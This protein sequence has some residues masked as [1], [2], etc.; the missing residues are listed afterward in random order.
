MKR[1][2]GMMTRTA[3]LLAL[4]VAAPASADEVDDR[5]R[6]IED[7]LYRIKDKLDGIVSDGSCEVIEIKPNSPSGRSAGDEQIA[8]RRSVLE[9]MFRNN[10]LK[11]LLQRCVKDGSL[12]IRY[13][14]K[15][16]EYCPVGIDNIDVV[17]GDADE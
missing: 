5:A 7:N 3:A 8:K 4:L 16:Y 15:Y 1:K 17:T 14:V 6:A 12:N 10:Q 11:P 2:R 13:Q 9:D